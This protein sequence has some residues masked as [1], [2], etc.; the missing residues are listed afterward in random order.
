MF[1]REIQIDKAAHK[2]EKQGMKHIGYNLI[3]EHEL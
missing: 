3:E 1:W 2:C